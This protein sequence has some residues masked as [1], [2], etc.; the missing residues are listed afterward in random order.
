MSNKKIYKGLNKRRKFNFK[1]YIT[2]VLCMTLI[3]GY[4]YKKI[5]LDQVFKNVNISEKASFIKDK[6]YFWKDLGFEIFNLTSNDT[7]KSDNLSSKSEDLSQNNSSNNT[8]VAVVD[9]MDVYLIQVG[10]FDNDKD[11]NEIKS[12]LEQ[13]K[14]PNATLE[15]DGVKKTQAYISLKE[16]DIRNQLDFTR[17]LFSDAFLTKLEI[18]TLS[19]EYTE[20]YSYIKNISDNLNSLL[21]SYQEESNYLNENRN[22]LDNAKYE[23]ILNNRKVILD[24]LDNEVKKIDYKELESF[25]NN[26]L[27]YTSQIRNNIYNCQNQIDRKNAYKY[28]SILISSIQMYYEFINKIK[29]A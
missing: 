9:G 3:I 24:K 1:K 21:N 17:N 5:K 28:E 10:S 13:N 2:I 4:T 23:E 12:K 18:P 15:V 26:L 19:L 7:K 16:Q 14:I 8:E 29:T 25:K 27:S 22:N 20:K 6:L 11:L